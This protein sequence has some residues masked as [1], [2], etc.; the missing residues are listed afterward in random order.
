MKKRSRRILWLLLA[1]VL[2]N[3]GMI[4]PNG[5]RQVYAKEETS[6][7]YEGINGTMTWKLDQ[8][9][10]VLTVGGSG[11]MSSDENMAA[12]KKEVKE[13]VVEDGIDKI[14]MSFSS[15]SNLE[16]VTMADSVKSLGEYI[17]FGNCRK[18]REVRLS[19]GIE[20]IPQE[21]FHDC[22][23]LKTIYFPSGLKVIGEKAFLGCSALQTVSFP[24]GLEVI[25]PYAFYEC[26]LTSVRIPAS[27]YR[28]GGV[29]AHPELSEGQ[30]PLEPVQSFPFL[31]CRDLEEIQ[32]DDGNA[33][34]SSR[35]GI[36]YEGEELTEGVR[37]RL[38]YYPPN[39]PGTALEIPE[40]VTRIDSE[41][42]DSG[43][44][45]VKSISLPASL[46][47]AGGISQEGEKD[48]SSLEEFRVASDSGAYTAENGVLFNKNK[49]T[50]LFYPAARKNES[51]TIPNGTE[52][53]NSLAFFRAQYLKEVICPEGL[54]RIGQYAFSQ[55]SAITR[56][57]LPESLTTIENVAFFQ[58]ES[59]KELR[60][61][62]GV[63]KIGVEAFGYKELGDGAILDDFDFSAEAYDVYRYDDVMLR[64]KSGS[65]AQD[66]AKAN[67]IKWVDNSCTVT[68]SSNGEIIKEAEMT[69]GT[70]YGSLPEIPQRAGYECTG[71]YT[72]ENGGTRVTE[73]T[74]LISD[75]SHTLYA[76]WYAVTE[77]S[78]ALEELNYTFI[79]MRDGFDYDSSYRIP[80]RIYQIV[81]GDTLR[82]KD[83]YK[84]N[85]E[86]GGNCFG[87]STTSSLF[88]VTGSDVRIRSYKENAQKVSELQIG[89][90]NE[91]LGYSLREFI[92]IMQTTQY[93]S[94]IQKDCKENIGELSA[95]TEIVK[96]LR[97]SKKPAVICLYGPEGGHA[98][99]G[100][101]IVPKDADT[102][103]LLVYD[104]NYGNAFRSIILYKNKTTGEYVDW[105][106]NMNDK[107]DWGSKYP[108][109]FISYVPY[110]DFE[111]AWNHLGEDID[112]G[113]VLVVN[114]ENIEIRDVED[115]TVA[116]L[117]NGELETQDDDIFK[118]QNLGITADNEMGD[119][120]IMLY[121]PT[122]LYTVE[123]KDDSVSQFLASMVNRNL[124]TTVSTTAG[125][126]TFAVSDMESLNS[127][128]VEA[129]QGT[130]YEITLESTNEN[131]PD[132]VEVK[133]VSTGTAVGVTQV[134]GELTTQNCVGA[135]IKVDGIVTQ[136]GQNRDPLE[137]THQYGPWKVTDAAT[138]L[139]NG[140]E[141]R[142]CTICG[143][144]Q[145]RVLEKLQAS[146]RVNEKNVPLQEKQTTTGLKVIM[147]TGDRIRSVT[148]DNP[149][150]VKA[151][152][153]NA[154][155]GKVKLKGIKKGKAKV[156]ILL[157]SGAKT[158]VTVKVQKE[159]VKTK[160]ITVSSSTVTLKRGQ[161][162]ALNLAVSPF[163]SK[164]KISCT[165]SNKK[166][167]TVTKAGLIKAKKKGTAKIVVRSGK[168]TKKVKVVVK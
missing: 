142:N 70:T 43:A 72:Q 20:E 89:D 9:T 117:K 128:Q 49:S 22:I 34:F 26:G 90:V 149:K 107:H 79:N 119:T 114:S 60:I 84:Y 137:H 113:N 2:W 125:R 100:Y 33:E 8:K 27:V 116:V 155:D 121:L 106:Y 56:I 67:R 109:S 31:V 82:A 105:Y 127:T 40:G 59:L 138:V 146:I 15:Y 28:L 91:K 12:H 65:A 126:V 140:A 168:K 163:T 10:G 165:S 151:S 69:P 150:S 98:V 13:I 123:N 62:A 134:G 35:G 57:K 16:K 85:K 102:D 112:E 159:K 131:T 14:S 81:F 37:T 80:L 4:L 11:T 42:F 94:F 5:V 136:E 55:A 135:E 133:G 158:T 30:I 21:S 19:D 143:A 76:H 38:L 122:D 77:S 24:Q 78:F 75:E 160:R 18:L 120:D 145:I 111:Y 118:M 50:L 96:N 68:F 154:A 86:W 39:H 66:Y 152:I 51:Y 164:E 88:N 17:I 153:A 44:C 29:G 156:S 166:V 130:N 157:Q 83:T 45:H 47:D 74:T 104:C 147:K 64:G 144:S 87:M 97:T 141:T 108:K 41:A 132:K 63:T 46:R 92:E 148:S 53:V 71:W 103:Q 110:E 99:I 73:N 6:Y 1:V 3:G 101:D 161:K 139:K 25:E 61:P 52:S 23:S 36:L 48:F 95:I 58:C 162:A 7:P 32:V 124:G 115:Q 54:L 93:M 129:P 167:A